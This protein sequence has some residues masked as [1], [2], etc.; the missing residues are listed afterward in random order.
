SS[1]SNNSICIPSSRS[2]TPSWTVR[3]F[4]A[5]LPQPQAGF[6]AHSVPYQGAFYHGLLRKRVLP[7][8][9][10]LVRGLRLIQVGQI[11]ETVV[12]RAFDGEGTNALTAPMLSSGFSTAYH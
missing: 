12:W 2:W 1:V 10:V 3:R 8:R 9:L 4:T 5:Q 6:S 11:R 7:L